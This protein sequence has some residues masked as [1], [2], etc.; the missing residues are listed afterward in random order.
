MKRFLQFALFLLAAPAWAACTV[1]GTTL[2][3]ASVAESDVATCVTLATA[4]NTIIIPAGTSTWTT[5]L[6]VSANITIE[7]TGTPNTLPAQFG[8]GTLSTHITD[9][10]GTSAPLFEVEISYSSGALFRLSTIDIEPESSSTDLFRPVS[11]AGTCTS[12]GCPNIRLDNIGFGTTTSFTTNNDTS[13]NCAWLIRLDNVF[14]VLDHDSEGSANWPYF[15]NPSLS[16]YLGVGGYGDN[17]WAQPDTY[18]TGSELYLE[19]NLLYTQTAFVDTE[20]APVGGGIGGA[21]YVARFNHV[22]TNAAFGIFGNHGL[23]TDGRPQSGRTEEV[24][25]NTVTIVPASGSSNVLAGIRGGTE[26]VFG[27]T[28]SDGSGYWINYFVSLATYR[29]VFTGSNGWGACGGSGAYDANDGTVYVSSTLTSASGGG[30]NPIVATDSS[31]SWTTNEWAPSGAPYSFYDVTQGFWMQIA[32]NTS[33][34]LTTQIESKW[35]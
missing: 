14:G 26:I 23:D 21:R 8:S 19:N 2:T 29:T 25:G 3:A 5:D 30:G 24:Y 10:A 6:A 9:N 11:V 32:S 35:R 16:A 7:G 17:S 13:G 33:D 20:I 28:V 4:G 22:T 18:G 34:A 15:V 31:K 12:G 27:N 1:S